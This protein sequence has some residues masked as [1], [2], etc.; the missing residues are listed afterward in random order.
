MAARTNQHRLT[1]SNGAEDFPRLLLGQGKACGGT[2]T[3]VITLHAARV[4]LALKLGK[5]LRVWSHEGGDAP[6]APTSVVDPKQLDAL[7]RAAKDGTPRPTDP[8][9]RGAWRASLICEGEQPIVMLERAIASY[10]MVRI[11]SLPDRGLWSW[12]ALRAEKWFAGT[13]DQRGVAKT[14]RGAMVEAYAAADGLV[15]D[16]CTTRD[17][18][19]RQSMDSAYAADHPNRFAREGKDPTVKRGKTSATPAAD[20]PPAAP[21][22]RGKKSATPAADAPPRRGKGT[23]EDGD[24]ELAK[25]MGLQIANAVKAALG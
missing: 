6:K 15:A 12:E 22:R 17:T 11:C 25:L 8:A 5:E 24:A 20:A 4:L 9:R 21:P 14:L 18:R 23:A 13:R 7:V 1:I 16:A 2:F 19:R 10:G 3:L